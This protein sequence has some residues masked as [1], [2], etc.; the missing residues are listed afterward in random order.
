M[1]SKEYQY[2]IIRDLYNDLITPYRNKYSVID[3][4][5]LFKLLLKFHSCFNYH[6]DIEEGCLKCQL[7]G[8]AKVDMIFNTLIQGIKDE[9]VYDSI[10]SSTMVIRLIHLSTCISNYL[11][12]SINDTNVYI[13]NI[14]ILVGK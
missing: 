4:E 1:Y 10:E 3:D 8:S 5:E 14:F 6:L 9:W 2:Q 13:I 11:K 12:I 7:L